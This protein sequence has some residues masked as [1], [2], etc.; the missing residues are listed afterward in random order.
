V[1]GRI[2]FQALPLSTCR[3]PSTC[4]SMVYRHISDELKEMALSMSLQGLSDPDIRDFTGISERS[5]KRVRSTFRD[6]GQVSRVP[7]ATGRCRMLTPM[8]AKVFF[9]SLDLCY[10]LTESSFSVTASSASLT[11]PS[12]SCRRSCETFSM[13]RPQCRPLCALFK[14]PA[15]P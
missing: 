1:C 9:P 8:E 7:L 2:R 5:M 3:P 6:T 11:W 15:I 12:W 14:G 10:L 4:S 13:S